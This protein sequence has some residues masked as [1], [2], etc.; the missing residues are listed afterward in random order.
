MSLA[1]E[2]L[3]E[4]QDFTELR[5]GVEIARLYQDEASG[6]SAAILR[7]APGA[8][9]PEHE[10]ESYEH[11]LVLEGE[12]CDHRGV[13]GAGSFVVNPPGSRHAITSPKGCLALLIWV[14]P[15]RFL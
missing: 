12:Q 3:H 1:L 10:H 6:A 15:V 2:S 5:P 9:V 13:Y 4:R 7:Y 11:V 8:S 14:R